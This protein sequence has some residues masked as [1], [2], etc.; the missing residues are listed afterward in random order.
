MAVKSKK[1][2]YKEKVNKGG[3][4]SKAKYVNVKRARN[5]NVA[6]KNGDIKY[7]SK[8]LKKVPPLRKVTKNPSENGQGIYR[9]THTL[10]GSISSNIKD[11]MSRSD[12]Y[13]QPDLG[14]QAVLYSTDKIDAVADK[15]Y[16]SKR[17]IRSIK[18]TK[19]V[20]DSFK[21]GNISKKELLR[22][23][24][25]KRIQA[26]VRTVRNISTQISGSLRSEDT[27]L[28]LRG[29]AEAEKEI[30]NTYDTA[31]AV[32]NTSIDTYR[33]V[34]AVRNKTI[35]RKNARDAA[36]SA[37]DTTVNTHKFAKTTNGKAVE[38]SECVKDKIYLNKAKRMDAYKE[39]I[40]STGRFNNK[41]KTN[42]GA[43]KSSYSSNKIR[44]QRTALNSTIANKP[45]ISTSVKTVEVVK[46]AAK[47]ILPGKK[48]IILI[49]VAI[50][51]FF[52]FISILTGIVPNL[53]QQYFMADNDVAESYRDKV[54]MLDYML[55]QE[56][57]DLAD[58]DSY[59]DV[60][61][62][63]IGDIQGIHTNFQ[64]LFAVAAVKFEQDLSCSVKEEE[65]IE[66]IYKGLYEIKVSTEVYYVTNSKGEEVP[67][68]RK[69]ITV[70]THDM[71]KAMSKLHFD[72]EQK[73]WTRRLVSGF[74]EQFPEFAQRYGELS[75]V[76][77]AELINNAPKMSNTAQRELFDTALSIVGKVKYFW[78]GKSPAGWNIEWGKD[79]LVT[80]PGSETTGKYIPFGLDCSGYVDWVFKTAGIGNMLSGGGTAYQYGQSYP[81]RADELQIGDL[82]FLQ[83]PN[84]SGINHVGIYIGKDKDNNNLYAHCE[85]GIGVTVNGFK[86]F[87]Y[88]RRVVNFEQE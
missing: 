84:S 55:Q 2:S 58:D 44:T 57:S 14:V 75:S 10:H 33:F 4:Q 47:L 35:E 9:R 88:F 19:K 38:G 16:S 20:A 18:E 28:G 31:A 24:A 56:I 21:K 62:V 41:I 69:L 23:I 39:R 36:A 50:C 78:G 60:K 51:I 25:A 76:E 73:A 26:D 17:V 83:M 43:R 59:N 66:D 8:Q 40:R 85:W 64:E 72:D 7:S 46:K 29:I 3:A 42:V 12:E 67:R 86:G 53:S 48:I 80:S 30:R 65:F 54:E 11:K 32:R 68:Y 61:I 74:S 82:A 63:Y 87:K 77:I 13:K 45:K 71:E 1:E 79:V 15:I 5:I 37:E 81:I 49:L 34:R 22:Q 27:D 70:Y 52:M 6:K